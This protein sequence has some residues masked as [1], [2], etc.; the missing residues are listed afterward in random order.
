MG[1]SRRFRRLRLFGRK[2]RRGA[3]H[4][5]S[6]T[7]R[8]SHPEA[9]LSCTLPVSGEKRTGR[10]SAAALKILGGERCER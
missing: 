10:P 3:L 4:D 6:D 8:R 2:R 7:M 5:L 9:D 1:P